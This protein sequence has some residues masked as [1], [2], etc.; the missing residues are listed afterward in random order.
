MSNQNYTNRNHPGTKMREVSLPRLLLLTFRS[1]RSMLL[2]GL[3]FAILLAGLK[4]VN[5]YRGREEAQ[6]LHEEYLTQSALYEASV[7]TYT[8]AIQRFQSK[9]DEK[10]SYFNDSLLMQIDPQRECVSN[11]SMVVRTPGLEEA[12][13]AKSSA[14]Q[15]QSASVVNASNVVHAY[16]SFIRNGISYQQ[17][18]DEL[19]VSE[20]S[21]RELIMV[22][23]DWFQFS[24]VFKL[25]ARSSDIELAKR[26][27]D[28]ILQ[29]V[30]EQKPVFEKTL[31]EH[32]ISVVSRNDSVVVDDMLA[33]Q[34][35]TLQSS[36]A[37]LQKDL[38]TSQTSLKELVK[39][40]DAPA[41]TTKGIIKTGIKYGIAGFIG[42]IFLMILIYAVRILMKGKILT[43]DELNVAYGLRNIMTYPAGT[44]RKEYR[45]AIDRLVNRLVND[46]PDISM[47]AANDVT[48][49]K[50]ESMSAPSGIHKVMLAG[51]VGETRQESFAKTLNNRAEAIGS[52]VTFE[53]APDLDTNAAAVRRLL[54]TDACIAVEEVGET[55]YRDAAE[56]IEILLA[57]GKP[58]LGTVYL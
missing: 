25:Q 45:S 47:S 23:T 20:E 18:A 30:E 32:E 9:I 11:V 29:Q 50:V 2:M 10:Q 48:I 24:S 41:A 54:T 40:T 19:G 53:A 13:S 8:D 27:M 36:I 28:Y 46:G 35:T 7:Q 57:S 39:P 14:G 55:S 22:T 58:V 44:G 43:D 16:D 56:I 15:T 42:G 5:E 21:V 52:T 12:D 3:V 6:L 37:Q 4:V 33:F 49:A 38:Q 17:F 34:Q 31:G 1:W 26:L 51:T